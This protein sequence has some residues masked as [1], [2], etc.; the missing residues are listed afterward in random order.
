[1]NDNINAPQKARLAECR[2]LKEGDDF[3][4]DASLKN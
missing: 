4:G 2:N 3:R 1:M